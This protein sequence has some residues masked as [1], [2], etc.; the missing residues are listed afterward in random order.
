MHIISWDVF[1]KAGVT[2][3][4]LAMS[5]F[6]MMFMQLLFWKT[7]LV[8]PHSGPLCDLRQESTCALCLHWPSRRLGFRKGGFGLQV[9]GVR[10]PMFCECPE[11]CFCSNVKLRWASSAHWGL[12]PQGP[13]VL[14]PLRLIVGVFFPH[15]QKWTDNP[16][17]SFRCILVP[18]WVAL[19]LD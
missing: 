18:S 4:Y 9:W 7:V 13:G 15:P 11:F 17:W 1:C 19:V 2:D 5:G 14:Q 10:V 12:Q 3:T 8:I 6:P 16:V